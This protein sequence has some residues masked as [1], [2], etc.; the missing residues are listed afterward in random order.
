MVTSFKYPHILQTRN[1]QGEWENFSICEDQPNDKGKMVTV[2]DGTQYQFASLI[3]MPSLV[4]ELLTGQDIRVI[5]INGKVRLDIEVR[6]F[7][8]E[9]QHC[10]LWV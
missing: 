2:G 6:R 1:D 9:H 8:D 3:F 7:S 5:D 10:R 4:E